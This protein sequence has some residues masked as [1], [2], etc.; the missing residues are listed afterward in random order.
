MCPGCLAQVLSGM[1]YSVVANRHQPNLYKY[2]NK[3]WG[4]GKFP[5]DYE[6]YTTRYLDILYC[7]YFRNREAVF[8]KSTKVA[9]L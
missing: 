1:F 9:N 6:I 8:E 5:V 2:T 3:I 4:G 7:T